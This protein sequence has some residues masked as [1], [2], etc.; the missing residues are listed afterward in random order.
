M[1]WKVINN[2]VINLLRMVLICITIYLCLNY[3]FW[4]LLLIL[5]L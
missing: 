2:I 1:K 3:S 5:L 4:W